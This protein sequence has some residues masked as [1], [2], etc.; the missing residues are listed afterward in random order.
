M[1]A[2][3][4]VWPELKKDVS[5]AIVARMA[6]HPEKLKTMPYQRRIMLSN[7]T[8]Q[9]TDP[10][11]LPANLAKWSQPSLPPPPQGGLKKSGKMPLHGKLTLG[12]RLALEPSLGKEE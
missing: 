6:K 7:F 1:Q 5:G 4:A 10:T 11:M 2:V 3:G 9:P 12:S 8:G